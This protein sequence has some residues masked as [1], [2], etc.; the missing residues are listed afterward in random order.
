MNFRRIGV[1]LI[2]LFWSLALLAAV[3]PLPTLKK[4]LKPAPAIKTT[5]SG[6]SP[7]I[8]DLPVTYNYQVSFWVDHFQTRGQKWFREWLERASRY[9]PFIQE[10]LRKANL[11]ADLAFM[12]MI[13]SG[14]SSHARSTA[15]AVGPWQFIQ[16]TGYRYGLEK[17]WWLDERK[18]LR[19]ATHAAIRYIKDLRKEFSSWYLVAAAYNMGENG[20]RRIIKRHGTNDY[21]TLVRKKAIPKET[22]E[23][24]PKIL[25]AM[26]ISKA[27]SLYGFRSLER[28]EPLQYD[29][30]AAPGGTDIDGLAD[31]IG[32]TRKSLR[33]LN[34]EL[35]LGYVPKNI[36]HHYI[37]VPK[38]SGKVVLNMLYD[39][40][41]QP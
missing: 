35:L 9:L 27:P 39:V 19:K 17:N 31:K 15:D 13:E 26:L 21:W 11:P 41:M 5:N 33:D 36:S 38:G 40:T 4:D 6:Q 25:A 3:P 24:V 37:R 30:I 22:Q 10:E 18:D 20:L 1:L 14:F 32:I 8:F 2:S 12:V 34:A 7:L 28:Y 23:Y 16:T 29:V